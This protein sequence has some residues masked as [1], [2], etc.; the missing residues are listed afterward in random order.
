MSVQS[1]VQ[2]RPIVSSF[3]AFELL[4]TNGCSQPSRN[5]A[6]GILVRSPSDADMG[7]V[8]WIERI[9]E[10]DN[11]GAQE[12]R[13]DKQGAIGDNHESLMDSLALPFWW[14]CDE[15]PQCPHPPSSNLRV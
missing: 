1:H 13:S 14:R 4:C 2:P 7:S 6:S 9:I 8:G 12:Y 11:L 15:T 5:R 3:H 10:D